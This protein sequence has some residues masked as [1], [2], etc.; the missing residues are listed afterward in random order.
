M[1]SDLVAQGLVRELKA[2]DF[3][4]Q[5]MLFGSGL[6]VSLLPFLILLSAF[7][8]ARVGNDAALRLGQDRQA[9]GI[10]THLFHVLPGH[11]LISTAR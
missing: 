3:S 2:R 9:P 7:P 5:V 4:N 10:V 1:T 6:L 11:G 8:S